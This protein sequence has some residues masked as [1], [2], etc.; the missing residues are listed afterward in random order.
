MN[1][2]LPSAYFNFPFSRGTNNFLAENKKVG[3]GGEGWEHED[4]SE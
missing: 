2:S 1:A 3:V 4:V